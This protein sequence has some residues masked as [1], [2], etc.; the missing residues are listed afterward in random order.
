MKLLKRA[1]AAVMALVLALAAT[2]C[3]RIRQDDI[4]VTGVE[5]SVSVGVY[6]AFQVDNTGDAMAYVENTN[7]MV[8][9][10]ID[11]K[12]AAQW[13]KE[14][15]ESQLRYYIGIEEKLRQLGKIPLTSEQQESIKESAETQWTTNGASLYYEPNNV[16]KKSFET[17]IYYKSLPSI[18]LEAMYGKDWAQ[19]V[20]DEQLLAFAKDNV[21]MANYMWVLKNA[22]VVSGAEEK[23]AALVEAF[24]GYRDGVNNGQMTW[25][26]VVAAEESRMNSDSTQPKSNNKETWVNSKN[27]VNLTDAIK[28]QFFATEPGKALLVP[29]APSNM[30]Y[31]FIRFTDAQML[32]YINENR[33]EILS[34]YTGDSLE[35][36][37]TA[38]GEAL[39]ITF[40]E[41]K[42][43]VL[44]IEDIVIDTGDEE[45]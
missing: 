16:S 12:P 18:L 14:Q 28:E 39:A 45:E 2:G 33:T 20:S 37:M 44:S 34:Q 25:A 7:D 30:I 40:D 9:Q 8:N 38:Y 43:S 10:T 26:D 21:L 41:E 3:D 15:T 27:A 32:S 6:R 11:G 17:Y 29:D 42:L 4:A 1:A 24:E 19:A 31:F 23:N 22:A 35:E 36:D 5:N 13:I